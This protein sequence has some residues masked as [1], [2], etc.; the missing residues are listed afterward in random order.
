M[1]CGNSRRIIRSSS[2]A[3]RLDVIGHGRCTADC[4]DSNARRAKRCVARYTPNISASA[5]RSL[6]RSGRV[7]RSLETPP[8]RRPAAKAKAMVVEISVIRRQN[9]AILP[10]REAIAYTALT[11]SMAE[12]AEASGGRRRAY[13]PYLQG[14]SAVRHP[15]CA[16]R[17]DGACARST[18]LLRVRAALACGAVLRPIA[19]RD[20]HKIRSYWQRR[21]PEKGFDRIGAR[22]FADLARAIAAAIPSIQTSGAAPAGDHVAVRILNWLLLWFRDK[23]GQPR[24]YPTWSATCGSRRAVARDLAMREA[25][26]LGATPCRNRR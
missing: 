4:T 22:W 5:Q 24:Y 26:G 12:V 11:H 3:D 25:L 14:E 20:E 23:A 17:S 7:E 1:R 16:C 6:S 18:Q 13:L 10:F 2:C 21:S 15:A 9:R 19:I 8:H